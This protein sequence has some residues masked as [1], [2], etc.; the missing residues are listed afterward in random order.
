MSSKNIDSNKVVDVVL[1]GAGIMSATLGV[2]LKELSPEL[3]IEIFE[4]LDVAAAESS[5]AWNN[6]GTGHSAFCELNYTPQLAD[7]SVETKKAVAI[8]ES[9]EVSKQFWSFLVQNNLVG[10]PESFIKS[11]PHM[12]FVWGENNVDFLKKRYTK[13]MECELFQ[14]MTYSEDAKQL[15]EWMPLV[16]NGR[17]PE[18]KVA[19]TRMLLGTDVNFGALTRMMLNTLMTKP[20]VDMEFNKEVRRLKQKNGIWEVKIKDQETGEKRTVKAKFVFIGAGGGSLPLLEK[21][22]IPEGKGFGGFPVSG[23]WLK[24]VNPQVIERHHAKVYGKAS[25]GA[26]PMSVPHLDTRM[27]DGK[28]ALL[29]GPYAGFSTRFL[30]NGSLLDLPLSIKVNNIRPMIAAGLDNIPLTKY[31]IDQVRQSPEDRMDALR[32]Y[33]PEAVIEDWELETAGQRVQVI[34]KHAEHGGI[35]EFGTE[36]VTAADGSIAALL[37]ASPGASTAVSIMVTLMERCFKDKM[38]TSEWKSKLKEMIPSY[39]KAL[40]EDAKLASSIRNQTTDVLNLQV[41]D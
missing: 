4:R 7:G 22:D 29:F 17:N 26:P 27:I 15:Q 8:A 10:A 36:V 39:G 31:L 12:S 5:D 21:S 25:V 23:Q 35:L 11:I 6:A 9:F 30:K 14:G 18:E 34:K 41:T 24:C 19:A 38:N 20:D 3:S 40:S 1:I 37:G 2:L 13:L 28:K 16:M 33:L 32:E